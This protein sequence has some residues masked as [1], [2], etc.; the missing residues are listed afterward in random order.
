LAGKGLNKSSAVRHSN[1]NELEN[2]MRA[3]ADSIEA[4]GGTCI[5]NRRYDILSLLSADDVGRQL[6]H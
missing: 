3:E 5:W 4:A 1:T 6:L 2:S